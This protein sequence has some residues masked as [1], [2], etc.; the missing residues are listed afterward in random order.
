[1]GRL[2]NLRNT[3]DDVV[4]VAEHLIAEGWTRPGRIALTGSSNGGLT[5]AATVA[6]R[7]DLF[8]AAL[9]EAG[10]HDLLRGPRF[11]L[12]WPAEYGRS[13]QA[14]QGAVLAALSPVHAAPEAPLPPVWIATGREDP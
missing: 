11:G 13:S 8:G 4:A 1:G 5:T 14:G 6:A 7:P 2:E 3:L 12:W 10:V 9:T